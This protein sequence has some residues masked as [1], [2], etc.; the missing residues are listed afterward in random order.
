M[1]EAELIAEGFYPISYDSKPNRRYYTATESR[2]LVGDVYTIS[3]TSADR[4][5]VEVQSSMLKDLKEAYV[6]YSARPR[7]DSTLGFFVD[8]GR[9]DLQN[10]EMGKKYGILT[11]KDADNVEQTIVAADNDT[12]LITIE[13]QAI[14]LMQTKWA[15]QAVINAFTTVP[16]CVLYEATPYDYVV[17]AQDVIDDISGTLVEGNIIVKYTNNFKEW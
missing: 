10:F 9:D 12:I 14:A 3:Y 2:I 17:T 8:G 13:S 4:N 11:I 5:I 6:S 15:K 1:T 7:V 16:E